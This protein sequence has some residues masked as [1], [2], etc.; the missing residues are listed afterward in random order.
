MGASRTPVSL[1]RLLE[2]AL[3]VEAAGEALSAFRALGLRDMPVGDHEAAPR[4]VVSDGRFSIGLHDPIVDGLAPI[5]VRPALRA[6]VRALERAG[7]ELERVELADDRFHRVSFRDPNGLEITLIEARTFAPVR[8]DPATV[9]AC[10]ELEELSVATDSLEASQRFW[11]T[12]GFSIVDEASSPYPRCR[13]TG[14]GLSLGLHEAAGFQA[15]LTF[16]APQLDARIEYLR[17][18]GFAIRRSAPI[19]TS[20]KAATWMAP[21]G[22]PFF[23]IES[24]AYA[25]NGGER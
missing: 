17:A 4:A 13:L 22:V 16:R 20:G 18:K 11:Q 23:L 3:P 10:G 12:L 7:I 1:G 2:F 25:D 14:F 8:P 19:G 15:A 21:G 6:H 24:E 5:F 9:F